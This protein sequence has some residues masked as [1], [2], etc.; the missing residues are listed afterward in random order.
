[1]AGGEGAGTGGEFGAGAGVGFG[2]EFG[3]ASGAAGMTTTTKTTTTQQY[4]LDLGDGTGSTGLVMGVGAGDSAMGVNYSVQTG[5]IAGTGASSSGLV[6]GLGGAGDSAVDVTLIAQKLEKLQVLEQ[7][8]QDLLSVH[9][10]K[11]W[12]EQ[13]KLQPQLLLPLNIINMEL[14]LK[15]LFQ[16]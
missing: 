15:E 1:M 8:R 7:I 12:K 11:E 4:G 3:S 10:Q 9:K 13:L 16:D 14:E 5:E 2:A 6:M